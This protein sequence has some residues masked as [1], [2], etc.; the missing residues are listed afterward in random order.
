MSVDMRK[1]AKSVAGLTLPAEF[2]TMSLAAKKATLN[3]F[4][5]AV[6]KELSRPVFQG[7]HLKQHQEDVRGCVLTVERLETSA[8]KRLAAL[9]DE[10][11]SNNVDYVPTMKA[12]VD[13]IS[14]QFKES[15]S[16]THEV[17]T[18]LRLALARYA[19]TMTDRQLP[20]PKLAAPRKGDIVAEMQWRDAM[21][22]Y[23][24]KHGRMCHANMGR[25]MQHVL[26]G[27]QAVGHEWNAC[28]AAKT[29]L[30][31]AEERLRDTTKV[32]KMCEDLNRK[33]GQ[34]RNLSQLLAY[35]E[36]AERPADAWFEFNP[37]EPYAV[38]REKA[39][40]CIS[41][42]VQALKK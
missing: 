14:I 29:A 18:H 27:M 36:D 5:H 19:E 7:A 20:R 35:Y 38:A 41:E 11:Q 39:R 13:A 9:H 16:S 2:A 22:E 28:E 8:R 15:S 33:Y 17:E 40:V 37:P 4:G 26:Q 6:S 30:F 42:M 25:L 21:T 3:S 24:E 34:A 10:M 1:L 23:A 31:R 32:M 12:C